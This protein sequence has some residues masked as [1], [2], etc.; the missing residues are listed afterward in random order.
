MRM[1]LITGPQTVA[2]VNS[3][4]S[5]EHS[6]SE[7]ARPG[8]PYRSQG[9]G[10]ACCLG[11]SIMQYPA[12][13]MDKWII[14]RPVALKLSDGDWRPHWQGLSVYRFCLRLRFFP[15]TVNLFPF[16]RLSAP[17]GRQ[18]AMR[19]GLGFIFWLLNVKGSGDWFSWHSQKLRNYRT[20][21]SKMETLFWRAFL[22]PT[23]METE[24]RTRFLGKIC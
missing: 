12:E 4:G 7:C 9:F 8:S 2:T 14:K 20:H 17:P 15:A 24:T 11:L 16:G 6:S 23:E 21:P 22:W 10:W 1:F 13:V 5:W 18:G 3:A 19:C